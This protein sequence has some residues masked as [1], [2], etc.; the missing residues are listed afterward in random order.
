M[1]G[2]VL[3]SFLMVGALEMGGPEPSFATTTGPVV[4]TSPG[5][6]KEVGKDVLV[7]IREFLDRLEASA[8]LTTTGDIRLDFRSGKPLDVGAVLGYVAST[9]VVFTYAEDDSKF[10]A[11]TEQIRRQLRARRGQAFQ[12]LVMI[13]Y[14]LRH[15]YGKSY[16]FTAEK[17]GSE[18]TVTLAGDYLLTFVE[19]AKKF[20][21]SRVGSTDPGGD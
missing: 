10:T 8:P 13:G 5:K 12:G 11:T 7:R 6:S 19:E 4:E 15:Y 20:Q 9:G 1:R 21:L 2:R 17:T 16:S 3:V 14:A 18:V